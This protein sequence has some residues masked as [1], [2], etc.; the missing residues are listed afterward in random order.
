MRVFLNDGLDRLQIL[1]SRHLRRFHDVTIARSF[2]Q[3]LLADPRNRLAVREALIEERLPAPELDDPALAE[4]LAHRLVDQD[5][6]LVSCASLVERYGLEAT[7]SGETATQETT[8]L[9]DEMAAKEE[10]GEEP[11]KEEEHWLEIELVDDD[12]NPVPNEAY[13]V[14]LPDGSTVSGRLDDMGQARLEGIDPGTAKV[15]FPNLDK[16]LYE[17]E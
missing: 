17:P 2:M 5:L 3:S 8:P 13:T 14:E 16:E 1:S 10:K 4:E 11:A 6:V 7:V 15:S 12:G 9:E